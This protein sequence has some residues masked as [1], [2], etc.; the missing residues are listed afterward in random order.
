MINFPVFQIVHQDTSIDPSG[1]RDL[2]SPVA[3]FLGL[4]GTGAGQELDFGNLNNTTNTIVSDTNCIYG[5]ASTLGDASGIFNLKMFL[6]SITDWTTGTFRFL[7]EK[8]LHFQ[9]N[10]V[11]TAAATPDTPITQPASQNLFVTTSELSPGGTNV[12]SGILDYHT[13]VYVYTAVLVGTD[14]P[15]GQYSGSGFRYRLIYDFS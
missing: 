1:S 12:I 13:T 15:I 10:K 9:P 14:V 8:S 7:E 11:L 3:G 4:L 2:L 6:I 5:R